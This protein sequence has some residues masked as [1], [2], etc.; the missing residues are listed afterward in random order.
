MSWWKRLFLSLFSALVAELFA[1]AVIVIAHHDHL[2]SLFGTVAALSIFVIP[3]WIL[4]IPIVLAF[5]RADGWRLWMLAISGIAIGPLII[6]A[7]A[8]ACKV[9]EGSAMKDFLYMGGIAAGISIVATTIYLIT[10]RGSARKGIQ[11]S[12]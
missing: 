5:N 3:G 2:G 9:S 6:A 8:Y 12:T 1:S 11:P 4:S 10:F 7:W